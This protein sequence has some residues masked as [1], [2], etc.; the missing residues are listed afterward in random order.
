MRTNVYTFANIYQDFISDASIRV[1]D[2]MFT[3]TQDR[4]WGEL[5]FGGTYAWADDKYAVYGE[6]AVNTSLT[7]FTKSY[8]VRGVIGIRVKW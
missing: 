8:D 5:G 2:T 4:T 1:A 3:T 6:G 7:N